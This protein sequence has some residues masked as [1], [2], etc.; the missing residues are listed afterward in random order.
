MN[1]R[2]TDCNA[3]ALATTPSRRCVAF[4]LVYID[5]LETEQGVE[6][7]RLPNG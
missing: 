4:A 3:D 7:K 5:L 1:P 6:D 2:P